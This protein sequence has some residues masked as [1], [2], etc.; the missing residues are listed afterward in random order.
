MC[1]HRSQTESLFSTYSQ[2]ASTSNVSPKPSEEEQKAQS[3]IQ[4]LL[5]KVRIW[6][7]KPQAYEQ[8]VG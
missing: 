4:E 5:E 7:S 8:K 1:A 3:Q 2:F 6:L